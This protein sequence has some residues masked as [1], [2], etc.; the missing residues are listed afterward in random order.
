MTIAHITQDIAPALDRVRQAM[1]EVL[2]QRGTHV[3]LLKSR[4]HV[5]VEGKMLRPALVLHSGLALGASLDDLVQA[6]ATVELLHMA[7]LMHDDVIDNAVLRRGKP[8]LKELVGN[9][10]AVLGGD[11]CLASALRCAAKLGSPAVFE[12]G[13]AVIQ[14]VEGELLQSAARNELNISVEQ[15][16]ERVTGKTGALFSLSMRLAAIAA[17]APHTIRALSGQFGRYLGVVFQMRDDYLDFYG[18]AE[19]MGKHL[20]NDLTEGIA[21]L[22]LILAHRLQPDDR[23]AAMFSTN[24]LTSESLPEVRRWVTESGAEKESLAIMQHHAGLA[25]AALN[26]LPAGENRDALASCVEVA[27]TRRK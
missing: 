8:S 26:C 13:E 17:D 23:L 10:A 22:P 11:Y 27:L 24:S 16:L 12:L 5:L 15:Y 6:A 19:S 18:V 2:H 4:E 25:L 9:K 14:I 7:T 21:T 1:A 20:G 3:T